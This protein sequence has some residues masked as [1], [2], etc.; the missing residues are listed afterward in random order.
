MKIS[1]AFDLYK[2]NYIFF[3]SHSRRVLENHEY[4]K[5]KIINCLG[6]KD[7]EK[8]SLQDVQRWSSNILVGRAWNTV[9]N[10]VVRLR[11][12]L[13]YIHLIGVNCLDPEL[14]PVP[15]REEVTRDFLTA[16]E[17]NSMIESACNIRAKFV[18]S[19][20]YS[21][22]IRLSEFLSLNRDSIHNKK[23]Q[24]VG[25]GQKTR[26]CFTDDRTI[27]LMDKY[28]SKRNDDNEALVVSAQ[29]KQRMT[30]TNV[31]ALVK[32]AARAAGINKHVTPHVLR[33]SFATNFIQNNGN[34][35]YLATILGHA[36]VSTTMIYT[37]I[38]DNDLE[39]QYKK[40]HT[41]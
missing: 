14:I 40:Y 26:L 37:H 6:D 17:V 23:F 41:V 25:K 33:H 22:G 34:I 31:Q 1:E 24:V 4:V 10:D 29:N 39:N 11:A 13:K 30:P 12:V 21:S 27:I 15:K 35:R 36:N 16:D 28:L 19:L 2:N 18:I 5:D 3:K 38:V 8:L 20:L 7:I 32:N 9:R